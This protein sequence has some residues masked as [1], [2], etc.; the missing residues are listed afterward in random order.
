[1]LTCILTL[2]SA[3]VTQIA[4]RRTSDIEMLLCIRT[5]AQHLGV[6]KWLLTVKYN[7]AF[8]ES[9]NLNF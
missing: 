4:S 6:E 1:M 2:A 7:K 9:V 5:Y 3:V 8:F